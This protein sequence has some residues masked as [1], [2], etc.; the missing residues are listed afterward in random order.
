M[1]RSETDEA[2]LAKHFWTFQGEEQWLPACRRSH[3]YKALSWGTACGMWGTQMRPVCARHVQEYWRWRGPY[4]SGQ[5]RE[6]EFHP[7][8][9][10]KT[11]KTLKSF[12]STGIIIWFTFSPCNS[13]WV[14]KGLEQGWVGAEESP[15]RNGSD[16]TWL[17]V[18][19]RHRETWRGFG[20]GLKVGMIRLYTGLEVGGNPI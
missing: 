6:L 15:G 5:G 8:C 12:N 19:S 1:R 7:S 2:W 11:L 10:G 13:C 20:S 4:W 17:S 14:V 3:I 18:D 16:W 9:N